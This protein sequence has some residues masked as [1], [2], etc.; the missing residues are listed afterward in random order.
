MRKQL[1]DKM[2]ECVA[3]DITRQADLDAVV[4][5][6]N[7][8]LRPGGGVAGAIHRAAG[9]RLDKECRAFAP[10]APGQAVLT[11]AHGLSNKAVVHALGPIYGHDKP[12]AQILAACYYNALQ[13]AEKAGLGSIGFPA[14]S[15]GAFGYPIE[16]AARVALETVIAHLPKLTHLSLVRFVLF[17]EK[18]RQVF[19]KTLKACLGGDS[20][21]EA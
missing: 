16:P 4:N 1:G 6:A 18:D 9:P 5:A 7:A 3:G 15:T 11:G 10:I 13:C 14:I 20:A 17:G 8:E 2:I 21:S 19:E 12:E